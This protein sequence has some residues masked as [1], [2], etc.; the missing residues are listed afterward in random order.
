MIIV[1]PLLLCSP[2]YGTVQVALTSKALES[3]PVGLNT[4]THHHHVITQHHHHATI[5]IHWHYPST[6]PMAYNGYH[7]HHHK[8]H[9]YYY[10]L[11]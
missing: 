5:T 11:T 6:L 10:L 8:N 9:H 4:N 7:Q 2:T 3:I 1:N